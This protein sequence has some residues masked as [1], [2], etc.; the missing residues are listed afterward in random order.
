MSNYWF[1]IVDC[2]LIILSKLSKSNNFKFNF[3]GLKSPPPMA[4]HP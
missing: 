2:N 3:D 4:P 1:M